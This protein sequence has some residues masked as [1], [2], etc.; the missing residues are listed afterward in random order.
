MTVHAFLMD[1][2][3]TENGKC[4]ICCMDIHNEHANFPIIA[5]Y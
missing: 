3:S 2:E 5:D 1:V 4:E